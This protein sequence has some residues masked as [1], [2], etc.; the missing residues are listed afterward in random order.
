MNELTYLRQDIQQRSVF[1]HEQ[2]HKILWNV[3]MVWGGTARRS[4]GKL[5]GFLTLI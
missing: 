5:R 4:A 3:M 2:Y 1:F